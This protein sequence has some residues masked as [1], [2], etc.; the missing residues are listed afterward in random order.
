MSPATS[1]E[2]R[3]RALIQ[4]NEHLVSAL[5]LD[6]VLRRV[7]ELAIELSGAQYGALGVLS[8]NA[9][10]TPGGKRLE[11]FIHVG[12]GDDDARA[13]GHLPDGHGLLGALIDTP[14][15]IRLDE[16]GADIRS[17]GF[18][19]KHPP[20]REFLGVPVHSRDTIFGN[21]YLTNREGGFTAQDEE[22]VVALAATAGL[23]IENARLFAATERRRAWTA[24]SAEITAALL[25]GD[26]RDPLGMIAERVHDLADAFVAAV[27]V[28]STRGGGTDAGEPAHLELAA[29]SG[30]GWER[31]RGRVLSGDGTLV[32]RVYRTGRAE[33]AED[34]ANEFS[35][36]QALGPS[37]AL[38][39]STEGASTGVLLIAREPGRAMF[40]PGTQEIASD[41]A[42][43]A[44]VALALAGARDAR[45]RMA[46][47]RDR[48]RIARELHDNVIQQLFG[49]GLELQG[50]LG[51]GLPDAVNVSIARVTEQLDEA[52]SQIRLAIFAMTSSPADASSLRH[53]VIDAVEQF[54]QDLPRSPRIDFRGALDS[55]VPVELADDV[56]AVVREAVANVVKHARARTA[57]VSVGLQ[58]EVLRVE[59]GDDGRGGVEASRRR[60]G[61]A[62]LRA[63]AEARG[64]SLRIDSGGAGTHLVWEVP[65]G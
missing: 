27:L 18:P 17:V 15:P 23:A 43:Q 39:L 57:S 11:R 36:E 26:E 44:S 9:P 49:S 20:M 6:V 45:Q 52:I 42:D 65:L 58:G 63:R 10:T 28:P 22:I 48:G 31:F 7:V 40:S 54:R 47:V 56:V 16:I 4:A 38:P 25:A 53:R 37:L 55:A 24:A 34:L 61:L 32:D 33:L 30:A 14:A 29:A 1:V 19:P 64:G 8:A 12:I 35:P 2:A 46:L 50:L 59:V 60:S 41:F 13:I 3:L 21:L 5:D 51:T 62:N